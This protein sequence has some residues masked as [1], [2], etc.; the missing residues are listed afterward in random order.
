M[1][2]ALFL[3]RMPCVVE[4]AQPGGEPRGLLHP[5]EDQRFRDDCQRR[6]DGATRR[7]FTQL[8][9]RFEQREHLNG[10]AQ[11]HVV[12]QTPAESE[13]PQEVYPAQAVFLV[14]SQ[15][16]VELFGRIGR[17]DAFKPL[18]FVAGSGERFVEVGFGLGAKERV[19]HADLRLAEA[20][21]VFARLAESREQAVFLQPVFG[22]HSVRAV[23][24]LDHAVA[25]LQRGQQFWKFG[26]RFAEIDRAAQFEPVNAGVDLHLDLAGVAESFAFGLDAPAFRHQFPDDAREFRRGDLPARLLL[27]II[28]PDEFQTGLGQAID[29]RRF[30]VPVAQDVAAAFDLVDA[31]ARIILVENAAPRFG[32]VIER[33]SR[34][35]PGVL[36]L[37][38]ERQAGLRHD[39]DFLKAQLFGQIEPGRLGF[40]QDFGHE[41]ADLI[42]GNEKGA[43]AAQDRNPVKSASVVERGGAFSREDQAALKDQSGFRQITQLLATA[44]NAFDNVLVSPP[45]VSANTDRKPPRLALLPFD[46][47]QFIRIATRLQIATPGPGDQ[48]Q[49]DLRQR[50]GEAVA[51]RR[52]VVSVLVGV[53]GG[54]GGDLLSRTGEHGEDLAVALVWQT[55]DLPSRDALFAGLAPLAV[56]FEVLKERVEYQMLRFQRGLDVD[57]VNDPARR[58]P[59]FADSG[60]YRAIV[61]SE[62]DQLL[63]PTRELLFRAGAAAEYI[64]HVPGRLVVLVVGPF[65]IIIVV[66]VAGAVIEEAVVI[67]IWNHQQRA[68]GAVAAK[69]PLS[70]HGQYRRP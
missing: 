70:F 61:E 22:Q 46:L 49:D 1:F 42:F 66:E 38:F 36:P 29:E 39:V 33:Q 65:V 2:K 60:E 19:E 37:R 20:Q 32:R 43:D 25:A 57:H 6:G 59:L 31:S 51:K 44:Q 35:Q 69:V 47:I 8:A 17:L 62:R 24:E 50:R 41:L 67:E 15:F 4:H 28:R 52:R 63:L 5:V 54:G 21:M 14:W 23:V 48:W 10:L 12:R 34:A 26:G 16:P 3:P 64:D 30:G 56:L 45:V 9:S 53:G 40:A 55:G 68:F 7:L 27:V 18:Q 11:S 13:L 58:R